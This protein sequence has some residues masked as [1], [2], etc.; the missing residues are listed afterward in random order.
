M[1]FHIS[2]G[3]NLYVYIFV[4]STQDTGIPDIPSDVFRAG[5][6]GFPSC[7]VSIILAV[8]HHID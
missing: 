7:L 4:L 1:R 3:K 6:R 8:G 2:I 5:R